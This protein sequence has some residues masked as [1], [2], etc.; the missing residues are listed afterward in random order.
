MARKLLIDTANYWWQ[1][2]H[3]PVF[4][5]EEQHLH[6]VNAVNHTEN[7]LIAVLDEP[8]GEFATRLRAELASRRNT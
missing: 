7:M 4:T 3:D 8:D 1:A 2:G 5:A 6:L